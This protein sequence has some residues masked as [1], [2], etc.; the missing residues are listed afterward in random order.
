MSVKHR[1]ASTLLCVALA[2]C[3]TYV[4]STREWPNV[5]DRAESDMIATIVSSVACELS[6][7]VTQVIDKDRREAKLRPSH[8]RY[9]DFLFDW[10]VEVAINI[11]V[12]ERSSVNPTV[13]LMPPS[14]PS[15]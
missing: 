11:T 8:K 2:G 4:P 13:L 5:S 12:V 10:G 9:T 14:G 15:S 6:Y 7:T 3:G 1:A